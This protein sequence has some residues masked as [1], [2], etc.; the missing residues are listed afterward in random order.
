VPVPNSAP[1][2]Q[3]AQAA[4]IA[5]CLAPAFA[6]P[7]FAAPAFATSAFATSARAAPAPAATRLA[8]A[9]FPLG[10]YL[11]NPNGSDAAAEATFESAY[12]SFVSTLGAKPARIDAYV[13]Y[14]QTI[15]NWPGNAAW[16]AWSNAQSPVA[17]SLLPV[18]GFPMASV[19][20]GAPPAD[21]Q[22]RAFAAGTYDA[23]I[24]GVVTAWAQQGFKR[25]VIRL[26]W[27]MNLTGPTYAGDTAQDQADWVA[28]YRHIYRIIHRTASGLKIGVQVVWNPG[29]TN[30]SNASATGA[31]YPG[32]AY[33][34][35][36]GVDIYADMYPY[37]DY[38][39]PAYYDWDTGQEDSTAAQFMAD[40]VN[41]AH[42]WSYPA[43][44]KWSLDSSGGH[45]Q[46]F[47]SLM[48]FAAQHMKTFVVPECGAG[49]ANAGTDVTD[50]PTF[51]QWLATQLAAGKAAGL[52]IGFVDVW[53][54]NGGGDYEFSYASDGKPLEA[55]AWG[56]YF[57]G[58]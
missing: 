43:A 25:L 13:D 6:P 14:T 48:A 8:R 4:L 30:Y 36:I 28:A 26:G 52:S 24:E 32:D 41:R 50:D 51:P 19:A 45:S 53:D 16:Q 23:Q 31:L 10:A 29:A 55:A 7:A 38:A 18:I 33:V 27:E 39:Y 57:G 11:G 56:Q 35:A 47:L 42:Y 17:R 9:P 40:P 49:N 5:A 58:Y 37:S 44:T 54:S 34:D 46:S 2:T 3:A 1:Q 15:A 20:G 22:F 21:A 12:A